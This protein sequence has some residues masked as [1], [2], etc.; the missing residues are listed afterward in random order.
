[1]MT[2]LLQFLLAND[3]SLFEDEDLCDLW[4]DEHDAPPPVVVEVMT[5]EEAQV[6]T[7]N[8]GLVV[9]MSY[10]STDIQRA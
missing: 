9:R 2:N 7:S 8:D 1:M 4:A 10:W 6:M 5:F 3:A